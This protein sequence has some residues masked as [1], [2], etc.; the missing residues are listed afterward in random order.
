MIWEKNIV[1]PNRPQMTIWRMRNACW[2]TKGR[3]Q[4]LTH[5]FL[6]FLFF[7]RQQ[8]LRERA[9]LLHLYVH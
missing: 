1:E 8:W 3:T 9:S 4:A 2:M 6:Y 7:S 5:N